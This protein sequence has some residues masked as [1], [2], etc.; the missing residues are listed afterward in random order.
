[1]KAQTFRTFFQSSLLFRVF[2]LRHVNAAE[3]PV[4]S[5]V[6]L[7]RVALSPAARMRRSSAANPSSNFTPPLRAKA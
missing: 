2:A 1:V 3:E 6:K 5:E 4:L 7:S